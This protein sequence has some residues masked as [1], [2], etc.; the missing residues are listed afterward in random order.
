[1]DDKIY[2]LCYH[3]SMEI[4]IWKEKFKDVEIVGSSARNGKNDTK[5]LLENKGVLMIKNLGRV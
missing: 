1:M 4:I 3:F 5:Q 2:Q